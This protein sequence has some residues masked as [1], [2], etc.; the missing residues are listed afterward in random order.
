[1]GRYYN[2]EFVKKLGNRLDHSDPSRYRNNHKNKIMIL[3][4]GMFNVC[5]PLSREDG[6]F[7]TSTID[8]YDAYNKGH[9]ISCAMYE[10]PDGFLENVKNRT[11]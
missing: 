9:Y 5:P 4:N 2:H 7:E 10:V 8:L 1:M 6:T 3:F 11:T